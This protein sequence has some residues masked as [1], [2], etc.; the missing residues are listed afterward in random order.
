MSGAAKAAKRR[1][2]HRRSGPLRQLMV[3]LRLTLC[4]YRPAHEGNSKRAC[5]KVEAFARF[6]PPAHGDDGTRKE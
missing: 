5:K 6:S 3:D 2:R 1:T 4:P